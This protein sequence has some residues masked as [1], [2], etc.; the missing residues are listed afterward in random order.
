MPKRVFIVHGWGGYQTEGWFPWLKRELENR[1][2]QVFVP[3]LPDAD[4]PRIQKWVPALAEAVGTAD[5]DTYFVGHSMGCQAITRYLETLDRAAGGTVFVA[6]FFKRLTGLEG[7]PDVEETDRHWLTAPLDFDK[8]RSN[9][10]ESIAIFSDDDPYVP[11]DNQDDFWDKLGSRIIIEHGK[12]HFSGDDGITELP[13]ALRA[14][15]EI[16]TQ[17]IHH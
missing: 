9:L 2:F 6:G 3:Q 4:K 14:V 12:R 10:G 15:E 1:G 5:S 7:D 11:L 13:I 17:F 8:V 16:T